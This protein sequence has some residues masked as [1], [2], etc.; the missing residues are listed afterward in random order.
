MG[1]KGRTIFGVVFVLALF[2][3]ALYFAS[4]VQNNEAVKELVAS[5]GHLGIF[6]VAVISGINLFVPVP[7]TAFIPIFS[8]AGFNI[9]II[10]SIIVVGTTIA[11]MLG[12]YIGTVLRP[13]ANKGK[14]KIYHAIQKWCEGRPY[15]TQAIVFVYASIVPLPNELLLIPLGALGVKLRSLILAFVAGNIIHVTILAYG[16]TSLIK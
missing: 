7:A 4:H 10:I 12:Y 11:D 8:A 6:L 13:R 5:F 15:V 2:V 14:N 3:S 1:D 16:L 9:V